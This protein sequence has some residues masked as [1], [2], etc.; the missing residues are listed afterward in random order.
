[1]E[2]IPISKFKATCLKLIQRLY[3]TGEQMIITKNGKPIALI[4]P[5]PIEESK[6]I[7]FGC[8]A[9]DTEII[10]DIIEPVGTED[11]EVLK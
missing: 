2:E 3:D 11:W 6:D 1:M 8:M 10:G 4:S 7:V 5:P 9:S